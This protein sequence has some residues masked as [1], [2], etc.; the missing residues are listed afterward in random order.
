MTSLPVA[1]NKNQSHSTPRNSHTLSYHVNAGEGRSKSN[2]DNPIDKAV[3]EASGGERFG[4]N[5]QSVPLQSNVAGPVRGETPGPRQLPKDNTNVPSGTMEGPSQRVCT[6]VGSS[7]GV[8][9]SSNGRYSTVSSQS[10]HRRQ[11]TDKHSGN[12]HLHNT[13]VSSSTGYPV[14]YVPPIGCHNN[15]P[16]MQIHEPSTHSMHGFSQHPISGTGITMH[17]PMSSGL[18][19]RHNRS[20]HPHSFQ[21]G[22]RYH[23][24]Y[25]HMYYP[26]YRG[27]HQPLGMSANP[28]PSHSDLSLLSPRSCAHLH[29]HG[30]MLHSPQM[31]S[32]MHNFQRPPG[33][34]NS[35]HAGAYPY[36]AHKDRLDTCCSGRV[37]H[38]PP[39][40]DRSIPTLLTN[41]LHRKP[42]AFSHLEQTAYVDHTTSPTTGSQP[43]HAAVVTAPCTTVTSSINNNKSP[44]SSTSNTLNNASTTGS[45]TFT[46]TDVVAVHNQSGKSPSASIPALAATSSPLSS[47]SSN[48]THSEQCSSVS[49][50]SGSVSSSAE[51]QI[52]SSGHQTSSSISSSHPSSSVAS[53]CVPSASSS[54]SSS[55][56]ASRGL[57]PGNSSDKYLPVE[58]VPPSPA[59]SSSTIATPDNNRQTAD[60]VIKYGETVLKCSR[61]ILRESGRT[62]LCCWSCDY[63]TAEPRKMHRH[64]KKETQ[65]QKCQLC[66][67]KADTRCKVNQ[68][69]KEVHM[70]K[71]DPFRSVNV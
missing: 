30:N 42:G 10:H 39:R 63:H 27:L 65:L 44:S 45:A 71:D 7:V 1:T 3:S 46:T 8:R 25:G 54:T 22:G 32:S 68:H 64:Q 47:R 17:G 11:P 52:P 49:V 70:D 31:P 53:P 40:E 21:P 26:H 61:Q 55:H 20:T 37:G 34:T 4:V 16:P 43:V 36:S 23:G 58:A 15:V 35:L 13:I 29:I 59:S 9:S 33:F 62:V 51:H 67:Y 19:P 41:I 38:S 66:D 18:S 24:Q 14:S 12:G 50:P 56:S 2:S 69:Y 6:T 5:I 48:N 57:P 60:Q 28:A